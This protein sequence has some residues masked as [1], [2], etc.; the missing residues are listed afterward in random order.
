MPSARAVTSIWRRRTLYSRRASCGTG[1]QP[2]RS[3]PPSSINVM[4]NRTSPHRHPPISSS[5]AG[6]HATPHPPLS[7]SGHHCSSSGDTAPSNKRRR[8]EASHAPHYYHRT[9][10]II[11]HW[12]RGASTIPPRLSHFRQRIAFAV[13][14][15]VLLRDICLPPPL[16]TTE[17]ERR[18]PAAVSTALSTFAKQ[19]LLGIGL[20]GSPHRPSLQ[21]CCAKSYDAVPS[22]VFHCLRENAVTELH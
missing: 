2:M 5:V 18:Y 14:E 9:P 22:T 10:P 19:A 12:R 21:R 1:H 7:E 16:F 3:P 8:L 13:V 17:S 4:W 20:C 6:H 11:R 15:R